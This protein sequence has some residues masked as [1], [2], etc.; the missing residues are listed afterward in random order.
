MESLNRGFGIDR[1][2][3]AVVEVRGT[4]LGTVESPI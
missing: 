2:E 3:E 1:K 4:V